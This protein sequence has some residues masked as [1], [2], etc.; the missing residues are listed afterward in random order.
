MSELILK[1]GK[2]SEETVVKRRDPP[3]EVD[4]AV[5]GSTVLGIIG[6]PFTFGASLLLPA[7]VHTML[8]TTEASWTE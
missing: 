4:V 6:A 2:V 1:L 7:G 3:T 8:H 5:W